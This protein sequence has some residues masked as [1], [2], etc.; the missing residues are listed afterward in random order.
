MEVRRFTY[1][2]WTGETFT[3]KRKRRRWEE[4]IKWISE[5]YMLLD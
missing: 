2:N 4:N 1:G 5:G 3:S